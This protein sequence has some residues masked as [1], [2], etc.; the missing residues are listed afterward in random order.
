MSAKQNSGSAGAYEYTAFISYRHT[1]QD[2]KAAEMLQKE[3]ESYVIP[4]ELRSDPAVKKPGTVFRGKEELPLSAD[5][6]GEITR[7]LDS[8]RFLIVIC[9]PGRSESRWCEAELRYFLEKHGRNRVLAVLNGG[10]PA[11]CFPP[12]LRYVYDENGK[13]IGSMELLAVDISDGSGGISKKALQRGVFGILAAILG[14]SFDTLRQAER[15]KKNPFAFLNRSAHPRG[16]SPRNDLPEE[17]DKGEA[18]PGISGRSAA[19][20]AADSAPA[21]AGV[22]SFSCGR[23]D[24]T[25]RFYQEDLTDTDQ[26][27]DVVVCSTFRG[28]YDA[29][30]FSLIG[31]L[32]RKKD[33]SVWELAEDPELDM[34]ELGGWLSRPTGTQFRQLLCVELTAFPSAGEAAPQTDFTSTLK[35]A[36]LTL[37][38][39]LE[40]AAVQGKDIRRI[41]LPILGAGYQQIDIEYIAPPLFTQCMHMLRTIPSLET[42][43]FYEIDPAKHARMVELCSELAAMDTKKAPDLF[44]S[45]STAQTEYAHRLRSGLRDSGITA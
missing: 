9:S 18:H 23:A 27:Y 5:L 38:N 1:G 6:P 13:V 22:L 31:S 24:Q 16:E 8:S 41:A 40:R 32:E 34:R 7:A 2:Q 15:Q 10:D 42:I 21:P 11:E 44:I 29:A 26:E 35:S 4:R 28:K 43:D 17:Q 45:Y 14:C 20:P 25:I 30:L 12:E 19:R 33:L 37:R 39:L 36:F 3:I